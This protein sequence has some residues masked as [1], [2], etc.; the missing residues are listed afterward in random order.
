MVAGLKRAEDT[1]A[2]DV[3]RGLA[4]LAVIYGHALSPW[5]MDAG[6]NFSEAAFLQWKFG[7]SFMMAFFFFVS[8]FAWRSNRSLTAALQQSLSLLVLAW[9]I[10]VGFDVLRVA[11]TFAGAAATLGV[12]ALDVV[13]FLRGAAR[14][15]LLADSYS[16]GPM[17]FLATL[18]IA[19]ITAAVAVRFG[20][21]VTII[22]T[23]ALIALTLIA[24]QFYWRNIFQIQL[25]G[26]AFAF[27]I[28][29]YALRNLWQ[30]TQLASLTVMTL[31]A[32]T[33][34]MTFA[35]YGLNQ[36]CH[37]DWADTCGVAWL[38]N[39]F[40]VAMVI[41]QFGNWAMFALTAF[42]G[43]CFASCISL[44]LARHGAV[45]GTSLARLGRMS[46]DLLIVNAVFLVLFTPLAGKWLVPRLPAE[47]P[48]FF[49][50]LFA[51]TLASNLAIRALLSRPLKQ[52]RV[53]AKR[54]ATMLVAALTLGLETATVMARGYRVSRGHE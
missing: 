24:D 3:G 17:W 7:A 50:A 4:I 29:G 23:A 39:R 20:R 21:D 14:L 8:G 28:A 43:V 49:I 32:L 44:M 45:V 11:L 2:L 9:L 31:L 47:G 25:L 42:I 15:A 13:G 18:G 34:A 16:L 19:R 10:N 30:R 54:I 46:M 35:T 36:G 38:N 40:G 48:V 26:V 12:P 52:L 41:G 51:I 53:F 37:W 1:N 27:F 22:V 6:P 5:F 33:G